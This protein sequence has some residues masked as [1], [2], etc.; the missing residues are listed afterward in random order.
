MFVLSVEWKVGDIQRGKTKKQPQR[1]KKKKNKAK[2]G[3]KKITMSKSPTKFQCKI[4]A[5]V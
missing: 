2:E 1:E 5:K 4:Y 3:E